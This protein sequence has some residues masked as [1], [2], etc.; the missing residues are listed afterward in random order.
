[1]RRG[2]T[3]HYRSEAGIRRAHAPHRSATR[4]S[5][6]DYLAGQQ[7]QMVVLEGLGLVALV[8][9]LDYL[10]PWQV[11]LAV[12]YVLPISLVAW[13]VGSWPGIL[14]SCVSAIAW[15]LIDLRVGPSYSHAGIPYWNSV[16][17]LA[18]YLIVTLT[19]SSLKRALDREKQLAST[20]PLTGILNARSYHEIAAGEIERARRYDRPFSVAYIDLDNFKAVN[21]RFGHNRG[22]SL[23]RLVAMTIRSNLRKT[24][25]VARLGGDEF[26]LLLPEAGYEPAAAVLQKIHQL[27]R[28]K[29]HRCDFPVTCSIGA[30]TF[31]RPAE[32]VEE[33]IKRADAC[34]YMAKKSGKDRMRHVLV[35][36]HHQARSQPHC[37]SFTTSSGQHKTCSNPRRTAEG[38]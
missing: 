17:S 33:L 27:L 26:V 15:L 21:D 35:G 13:T 18:F 24:D 22:D 12:F 23:L 1:V 16:V 20:D 36:V 14:I 29:M 11:S 3:P 8:A 19:L 25:I 28:Q 30:V 34:M 37:E 6:L 7:K 2:A 31:L 10:T 5:A 32:S 4:V 9:L 38:A